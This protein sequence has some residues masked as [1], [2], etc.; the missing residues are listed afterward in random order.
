MPNRNFYALPRAS[1]L[2]R[3]HGQ[4]RSRP[5]ALRFRVMAGAV[6]WLDEGRLGCAP[7]VQRSTSAPV[8]AGIPN[9]THFAVIAASIR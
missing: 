1:A 4:A 7:V 5:R 9:I 3:A 6:A 8:P 2:P